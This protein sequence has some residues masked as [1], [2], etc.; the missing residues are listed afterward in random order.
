MLAAN[1]Q[2]RIL[3]RFLGALSL[4]AATAIASAPCAAAEVS[5]ARVDARLIKSLLPRS[6]LEVVE[7]IQPQQTW[8]HPDCREQRDFDVREKDGRHARYSVWLCHGGLLGIEGFD[9]TVEESLRSLGRGD[10]NQTDGSKEE[11]GWTFEIGGRQGRAIT[12]VTLGTGNASVNAVHVLPTAAIRSRDDTLNLAVATDDVQLIEDGHP[13]II[14]A[15]KKV[16]QILRAV[17]ALTR[18]GGR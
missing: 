17:D 12:V 18:A 9:V 15:L 2:D 13:T 1:R 3:A 14:E 11:E 6:D 4:S 5:L 16:E 8:E 7:D 10:P